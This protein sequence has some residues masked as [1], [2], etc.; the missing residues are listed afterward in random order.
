MTPV[1]M[2]LSF[3][4]KI[5][6]SINRVFDIPSIDIEKY[7]NLSIES[8]VDRWYSMYE[9]NEAS[10]KRLNSLVKSKKLTSVDFINENVAG[11]KNLP[12][13][14]FI[15]LPDDLRYTV[16][17][18]V[19]LENSVTYHKVIPINLDYYN[20]HILNSFKKPYNR[21]SWRIDIGRDIHEIITDGSTIS[22][23]FIHYIKN[24]VYI[25]ISSNTST[26]INP[27]F[28]EEIIDKAVDICLRTLSLKTKEVN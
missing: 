14:T 19:K 1:Q 15:E 28:H 7:I 21:L 16:K 11:V 8:F 20:Q 26:D 18:E 2:Q 23:Y 3:L 5:G 17:E 12:N 6:E 13:G 25:S 10:R 4:Q 27:D 22:E 9:M 24:P